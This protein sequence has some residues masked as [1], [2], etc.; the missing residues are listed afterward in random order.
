MNSV[1]Q[2]GDIPGTITLQ[3]AADYPHWTAV[4]WGD[5]WVLYGGPAKKRGDPLPPV[6]RPPNSTQYQVFPSLDAVRSWLLR[7][8]DGGSGT[9]FRVER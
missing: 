2:F 8:T 1:D 9:L 7:H 5:G 6:V 3:E 4:P